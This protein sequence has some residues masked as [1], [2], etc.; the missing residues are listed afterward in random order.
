MLDWIVWSRKW[1]SL[2]SRQWLV[3]GP[4]SG[5]IYLPT[6]PLVQGM[7]QGQFLSGV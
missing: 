6:P 1:L 4:V 2:F 3:A 5:Y 7:T